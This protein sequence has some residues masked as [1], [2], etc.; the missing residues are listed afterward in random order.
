M[1]NFITNFA[2]T[3]FG[4]ND[5]F[6]DPDLELVQHCDE[7]YG[8]WGDPIFGANF[9]TPLTSLPPG[10]AAA[11]ANTDMLTYCRYCVFP[12]S[13]RTQKFETTTS[14]Q[15][16]L[17]GGN[18]PGSG[19]ILRSKILAHTECG[20][21]PV[22]E[23]TGPI[24]GK[25]FPADG[26]RS[27]FCYICGVKYWDGEAR[28]AE[29]AECEHIVPFFCLLLCVGINNQ[30]HY[31]SM[32]DSWWNLNGTTIQSI[33]PQFN[34]AKYEEIRDDIWQGTYRWS[35]QPCNQFKNDVPFVK[36]C[37]AANNNSFVLD[38]TSGGAAVNNNP[39]DHNLKL[40]CKRYGISDNLVNHLI[41]L[42]INI[43]LTGS[44]TEKYCAGW[45]RLYRE[46]IYVQTMNYLLNDLAANH[47]NYN[48]FPRCTSPAAIGLNGMPI[49]TIGSL[50][51]QLQNCDAEHVPY[52]GT[53]QLNAYWINK[54][55]NYAKQNMEDCVFKLARKKGYSRNN[56]VITTVW[57]VPN[58]GEIFSQTVVLLAKNFIQRKNKITDTASCIAQ[59]VDNIKTNYL[60]S[61]V[62]QE[63]GGGGGFIEQVGGTRFQIISHEKSRIKDEFISGFNQIIDTEYAE[64][65]ASMF[66]GG[67]LDLLINKIKQYNYNISDRG[68]KLIRDMISREDPLPQERPLKMRKP[69]QPGGTRKMHGGDGEIVTFMKKILESIGD[70]YEK[71]NIQIWMVYDHCLKAIENVNLQP[72]WE[73]FKTLTLSFF[74][75]NFSQNK[76]RPLNGIPY[77]SITHLLQYE[78]TM[79]SDFALN[80]NMVVTDMPPFK[81]WRDAVVLEDAS[82]PDASIQKTKV[83][84]NISKS[85]VDDIHPVNRIYPSEEEMGEA[86]QELLS[87]EKAVNLRTE[88][89]DNFSSTVSRYR[90]EV[91]L[92]RQRSRR[93]L[94]LEDYWQMYLSF[95]KNVY[96]EYVSI[97]QVYKENDCAGDMFLKE[98]QYN[99][100]NKEIS[101]LGWV[102]N[103]VWITRWCLNAM[104]DPGVMEPD[105]DLWEFILNKP[106]IL[107]RFIE[108]VNRNRIRRV[109][110][111]R[112]VQPLH[113]TLKTKAATAAA[114]AALLRGGGGGKILIN[115]RISKKQQEKTI[116]NYLKTNKSSIKS[117][118][119]KNRKLKKTYRKQLNK[120]YKI[121]NKSKRINRIK[122]KRINRI[123]TKRINKKNKR[124]KK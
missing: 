115:K 102:G 69:S 101:P 4:K 57:N 22:S 93:P 18:I 94:V 44:G 63:V 23:G 73:S 14:T 6:L 76:P 95:V 121:I 78:K 9:W 65:K 80:K 35:C 41:S 89:P 32:A 1:A 113:E 5:N 13:Q 66:E 54:R 37:L 20:Y 99:G 123:K 117:L 47:I 45:R 40:Y 98:I 16:I 28:D 33:Y 109:D 84:N 61:S 21:P 50:I 92:D 124:N 85:F 56:G 122:S 72:I 62:I 42:L 24:A 52:V 38:L 19:S 8:G 74:D 55:L 106:E 120:K 27:I 118:K 119:D 71:T 60:N 100:V 68:E 91:G 75:Y 81:H 86:F 103:S 64:V 7:S 11:A 49:Y 110:Y 10:G 83:Y 29:G 59:L 34:K 82:L 17:P 88:H 53:P 12:D 70:K 46:Q 15:S 39:T 3:Q 67:T 105:A 116:I 43:R 97:L 48:A 87:D 79:P 2:N 30:A 58:Y 112:T 31:K 107:N 25:C 111:A 90:T 51:L 114:A 77:E 108:N 104:S 26:H 96:S 36:I